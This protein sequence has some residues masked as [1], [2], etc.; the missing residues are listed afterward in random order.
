M[1]KRKGKSQLPFDRR[2]GVTVQS[3]YMLASKA[4]LG[5]SAQAKVLLTLMHTH[6]RNDRPVGYGIREAV[7]KIP[8]AKGTAQKVFK[9]LEEAGFI[10]KVDESLFNSRVGS[11]TRTWHLTWLP[12]KDK[13]PTHDWEN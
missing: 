11:K 5:L 4:F 7:E 8:C 9:E 1:A 12:F 6:W 13:P 10:E 3:K 2:G